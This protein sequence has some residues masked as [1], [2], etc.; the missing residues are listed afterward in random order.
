MTQATGVPRM[1]LDRD[2]ARPFDPSPALYRMREAGPLA[3]VM[4]NSPE[5]AWLVTRYEDQRTLL[6]D[7]RMSSDQLLPG[8]PVAVEGIKQSQGGGTTRTIFGMDNPRHDVLRRM[9]AKDFIVRKVSQLRPLIQRHVDD[10]IDA[11]LAGPRPANFVTSFAL[12]L[13]TLVIS[14]IFGVP[15]QDQKMFQQVTE[16]IVDPLLPKEEIAQSVGELARYVSGLLDVKLGEPQ[17]DMVSRLAAY[18]SAGEM[19]REEAIGGGMVLIPAGHETTANMIAM[20]TILLLEN[21]SQLDE[22][23]AGDNPGLTANAVEELLRYVH[24]P[25]YGRRRVAL[26]DIE[27]AGRVIRQGDGVI[28]AG[29]IADREPGIFEGD[30]DTFDIHRDAR[31]HLAFGYGIHQCLGQPLARAELQIVLATLFRR[32]PTL[33]IAIPVEQVSFLPNLFIYGVDDLPVTW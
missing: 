26:E 31:H 17:D 10:L 22:I 6:S 14:D 12:A 21:P 7:P 5:P 19:T 3:L 29:N 25:H 8:F 33:R 4:P 15:Y 23:R 27:I 9:F 24:V 2:P 18:V 13:P 16:K 28:L 32:I 11:M 30:P 20:S 1:P